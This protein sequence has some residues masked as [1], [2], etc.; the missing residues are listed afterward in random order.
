[1]NEILKY[2]PVFRGMVEEKKVLKSFDFGDS[3]YPCLE[4]IKELDQT[5]RENTKPQSLSTKKKPDKKFEDVYLPLIRD[6]KAEKV[7]VDL[8]TQLVARRGMKK[9]TIEFI[10]TVISKRTVRT[11]YMQKFIPLSNKVIPVIS[12]YSQI[13]GEIGSIKKQETDL[14]KDF[15]VLAF[16][17]FCKT[18]DNDMLQIEAVIKA[19]DYLIMD[20]EDTSID[21]NIDEHVEIIDKLNSM[22]CTVIVHRNAFPKDMTMVGLEHDKIIKYIDNRREI[23][24]TKI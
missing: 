11:Q 18:F 24:R 19:K 12:T 13:S 2:M 6:I 20:W 10:S 15:K 22:N 1:M 7:F 17:T 14:R 21:I 3:I 9:P 4:I 5:K 23:E 8:P 16:R